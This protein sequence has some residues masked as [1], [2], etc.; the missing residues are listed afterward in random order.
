[1]YRALLQYIK[2]L[3]GPRQRHAVMEECES[4]ILYS[5]DLNP[6]LW[7]GVQETSAQVA[8]VD[9]PST[10]VTTDTASAQMTTQQ[11]RHREIVF[12][13]SQVAD[14]Q[15]LID[16]ILAQRADQADIEISASKPQVTACSR[17]PTCWPVSAM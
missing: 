1:M 7:S 11:T 16:D 14:S 13:D 5:A 15:T 8:M 2:G 9:L 4:R 6:A 12:V 3:V 17:S 10:T